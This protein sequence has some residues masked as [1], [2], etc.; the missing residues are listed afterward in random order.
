MR[1]YYQKADWLESV[2]SCTWELRQKYVIST[3]YWFVSK[4]MQKPVRVNFIKFDEHVQHV[5]RKNTLDPD[6]FNEKWA[7]WQKGVGGNDGG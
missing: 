6:H 7:L 2:S 1:V 3:L 4:I 5:Q